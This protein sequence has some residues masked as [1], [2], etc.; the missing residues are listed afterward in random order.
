[1][2]LIQKKLLNKQF[3][4][5][6]M[7]IITTKTDLSLLDKIKEYERNITTYYSNYS[8][9]FE[10][11]M[12]P[13]ILQGT[14]QII[15][16]EENEKIVGFIF[17]K[18]EEERKICT[19]YVDKKYRK[20]GLG[21]ILVEK[22]LEYLETPSPLITIPAEKIK[23]YQKIIKKFNWKITDSVD[24]EIIVNGKNKVYLKK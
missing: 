9:W 24:N 18:K 1:M 4:I 20:R 7:K 8:D 3:F 11:K 5:T 16:I 21:T 10:T 19:L 22:G 17:L 2:D 12:L 15:G 6:R 14:R 23:I 13:G